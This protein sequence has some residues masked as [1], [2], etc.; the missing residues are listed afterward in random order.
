MALHAEAADRHRQLDRRD[1]QAVGAEQGDAEQARR[2]E[3]EQ[4]ARAEADR[5]AGGRRTAAAQDQPVRVSVARQLALGPTSRRR[6]PY[7]RLYAEALRGTSAK[8][9]G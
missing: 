9:A 4:Q 7:L 2:D 8:S 5:I 6:P 1:G 3:Q